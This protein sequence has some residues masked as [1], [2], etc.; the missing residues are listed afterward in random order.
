MAKTRAR[1]WAANSSGLMAL[2]VLSA[3]VS[4]IFP[5]GA[6]GIW[7][8]I[9]YTTIAGILSLLTWQEWNTIVNGAKDYLTLLSCG[10]VLTMVLFTI[11]AFVEEISIE[12]LLAEKATAWKGVGNI[13]GVGRWPYG[14][15]IIGVSFSSFVREVILHMSRRNSISP[16]TGRAK[17]ARR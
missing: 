17:T 1:I 12:A 13:I 8:L 14:P 7:R 3:L 16:A 5:F 9:I 2:V 4:R 10:V 6:E 11:G 15:L